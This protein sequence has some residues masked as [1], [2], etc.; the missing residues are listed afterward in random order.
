MSPIDIQLYRVRAPR[1]TSCPT[2]TRLGPYLGTRTIHPLEF[3]MSVS[4]SSRVIMCE[5]SC[6]P[7]DQRRSCLL[8]RIGP[9]MLLYKICRH[10]HRLDRS[11]GHYQCE[12]GLH[13]AN[14][15]HCKGPVSCRQTLLCRQSPVEDKLAR[16]EGQISRSR[17]SKRLFIRLVFYCTDCSHEHLLSVRNSWVPGIG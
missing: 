13:G 12:D 17:H 1:T 3:P 6:L 16:P 8:T 11:N 5:P 15:G 7:R 14:N 2:V 9:V 10:Y 4:L